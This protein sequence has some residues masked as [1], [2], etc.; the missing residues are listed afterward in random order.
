MRP[1]YKSG[2]SASAS[3]S[4]STSSSAT[5]V[6]VPSPGPTTHATSGV[7]DAVSTFGLFVTPTVENIV[8]EMT[9]LE[10]RRKYGDGWKG[11]DATDLRAYVGLL[12]LASVYRSRGEA[13]ASLWDAESGR[14]IFRATMPLKVFHTYSRLLRFDDHVTRRERRAS[15]KLAAVREVWDAWAA[16]L[17]LLYNPGPEVTVDEQL[18]PFRGRCP[19]RQYMPSKPAKYGIKSWVACDAR[20]SYAWKMQ[21]YT[22]KPSGGRP[23]RNLGLRVVLDL[24][25]GLS[26]RN[27]TCDNYFTSYE[28]ARQL[29]ERN[30]TVVGTVRKNKPELPPRL[31]AVKGRAAFSSVF[32]FTP[33]ATL[34]SYVPRKKNRNVV[35]LSTRH[36]EADVSDRADGKPVVVLDYNRNKGGVDNLDKVIGTYSCRRMTARWPLV[37]F[38]N[39]LDVSSY[40][41]FVIWREVNPDWMPG[42]RNKRRV[43]LERLGKALVAPYIARRERVPRTEA[44][45]AVVK[46]VKVAAAAAAETAAAAEQRD[47]DSD[48]D[49]A[50][51][52]L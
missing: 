16:R 20:S 25:E 4:T 44:S 39:I 40:N 36:S 18:V 38:H 19:F 48:R 12:I 47:D 52:E 11:M 42:K 49:D 32:A 31:L 6:G 30:V 1:G 51:P 46:A 21:V 23:E 27:V 34:V 29:L 15:D 7:S 33:A 43:F 10:G 14:A 37:V 28:L 50:R 3:S 9:N 24:T 17:P 45:A 26:G 22:G 13:A 41:A 5:P 35:L 8:L 2:R